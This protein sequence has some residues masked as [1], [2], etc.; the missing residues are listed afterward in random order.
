MKIINVAIS[1]Q[2]IWNITPDKEEYPPGDYVFITMKF[3]NE[4]EDPVIITN[5]I[6]TP[7]IA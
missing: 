7:F 1:D 5:P 2:L 3:K 6:A 4:G